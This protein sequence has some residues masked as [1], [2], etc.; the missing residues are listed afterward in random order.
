MNVWRLVAV[1]AVVAALV[2]AGCGGDDGEDDPGPE[3]DSAPSHDP[4]CTD[5]HP[6][7]LSNRGNLAE[8]FQS[9]LSEDGGSLRLRNVSSLLL[10][11]KN[12]GRTRLT[13][14]VR[15]PQPKTFA[16]AMVGRVASAYCYHPGGWCRMPPKAVYTAEGPRP[17]RVI[18]YADP[19]TTAAAT[20]A[21]S[22][23]SWVDSKLKTR[24]RRYA[25]SIKACAEAVA[26]LA[27]EDQ[28]VAD[29]IRT[30][31]EGGTAC[32]GLVQSV[33][34]EVRE[35]RAPAAATDDALRL[36]GRFSGN[37]RRDLYVFSAVKIVARLR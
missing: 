19:L 28:V 32:T 14:D 8:Q 33:H 36:A 22:F 10:I 24:A 34:N 12:N 1:L 26:K 21:S 18:V 30:A 31:V 16:D 20:A 25:D 6:I 11:V 4:G 3:T 35:A 5:E 9:C 2:A 13:T 15:T 17:V 23:G 37:L 29:A 27:G 7:R